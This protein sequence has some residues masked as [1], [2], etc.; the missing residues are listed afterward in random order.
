MANLELKAKITAANL[1]VVDINGYKYNVHKMDLVQLKDFKVLL[2]IF[3]DISVG[4]CFVSTKWIITCLDPSVKPNELL[5]RVDECEIV[6]SEGFE[7][8]EYL[9]TKVTGLF[10]SSDK[11]FLRTIG[12]D[13]KPFYNATLKVQNSFNQSFDV[14]IV[15]FGNQAKKLSTMKTK[16]VIECEVTVKRSKHYDNMEFAIRTVK[17]K[18]EAKQQ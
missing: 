1:D 5:V 15:A 2:P 17:L 13:R 14:Y 11:C 6:P 7:M 3:D 9:N 16:S 12:P 4:D 18:A 8:T 10:C